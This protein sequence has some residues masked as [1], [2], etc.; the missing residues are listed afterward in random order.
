MADD[1]SENVEPPAETSQRETQNIE[2]TAKF[3]PALRTDMRIQARCSC[4]FCW[5][6]LCS[7]TLR[8][9]TRCLPPVGYWLS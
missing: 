4:S 6:W 1:R 7:D 8:V 3:D 5:S 9:S 2:M